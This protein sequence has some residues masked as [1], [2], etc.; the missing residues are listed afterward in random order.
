M[1]KGWWGRFKCRAL[2]WHT[3]RNGKVTFDGA[4]LHAHCGR[5]GREVMQDSQ[6]NW[7]TFKD[8]APDARGPR[9]GGDGE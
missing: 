3:P 8:D 2:G 7:F 1:A 9:T 4:S 6:G 5:C